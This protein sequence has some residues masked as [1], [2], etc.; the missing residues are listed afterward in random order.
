M[1]YR[2]RPGSWSISVLVG[3]DNAVIQWVEK[4]PIYIRVCENNSFWQPYF[5]SITSISVFVNFQLA[6]SVENIL[7]LYVALSLKAE[8]LPLD[9]PSSKSDCWSITKQRTNSGLATASCSFATLS[10]DR[11]MFPALITSFRVIDELSH[12]ESPNFP[13]PSRRVVYTEGDTL[14]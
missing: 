12:S 3:N 7:T 5:R 10:R 13:R 8:H 4:N 14:S 2:C 1:R 6:T 11:E 9:I